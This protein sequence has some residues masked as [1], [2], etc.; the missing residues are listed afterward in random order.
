LIAAKLNA[1][2]A[3]MIFPIPVDIYDYS[4]LCSGSVADIMLSI[5]YA[6]YKSN[7][8]SLLREFDCMSTQGNASTTARR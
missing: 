6:Q 2:V 7:L 8:V 4:L 3:A 5:T 1:A